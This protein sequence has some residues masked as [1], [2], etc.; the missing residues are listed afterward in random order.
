MLPRSSADR[1]TLLLTEPKY[2]MASSRKSA[3]PAGPFVGLVGRPAKG[4]AGDDFLRPTDP[5]AG[6]VGILPRALRHWPKSACKCAVPRAGLDFA[7]ETK[8]AFQRATVPF[9][10]GEWMHSSAC[11]RG[12]PAPT[13]SSVATPRQSFPRIPSQRLRSASAGVVPRRGVARGHCVRCEGMPAS[14]SNPRRAFR[15][16]RV[17]STRRGG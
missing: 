12:G 11:R 17:R 14:A 9:G 16:R 6:V 2:N 1:G 4:A 10:G 15:G 5:M 7:D 13:E 8:D 3:G